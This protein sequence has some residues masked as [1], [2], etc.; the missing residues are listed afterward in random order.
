MNSEYLLRCEK[1]S[2]AIL[3]QLTFTIPKNKITTI[4]GPSGAGKSSLL[5][6]LNRLEEPLSGTIYFKDKPISSFPIPEL[7]REIG[8]V[9]QSP[10][11]FDGTVEDNLKYG[12]SLHDIWDP[13][14]GVRLLE[15][16]DLPKSYLDRK[17]DDLSGGEKQR[18]ALARTLANKPNLLLLDE[19]TSS[20]D[21]RTTELIET[22][23]LRIKEKRHI[24]FVMVTHNIEQ[25]KRI[26]DHSLFIKDG[27]LIESGPTSSLLENPS[28][29]ALQEF[30]KE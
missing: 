4:I 1:V 11:L 23:L 21:V 28:S 12:P 27:R 29:R 13:E 22:M 25:S 8:L 7:R 19:V 30:L 26:G 9:F 10:Y 17:V 5:M 14:E 15:L 20:L 2:T 18:I 6:L 24:P 3:D 16:V